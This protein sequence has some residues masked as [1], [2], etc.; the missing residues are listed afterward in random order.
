[1]L[2]IEWVRAD[3]TPFSSPNSILM[4]PRRGR[5]PSGVHT[6]RLIH[7]NTGVKPVDLVGW[8]LVLWAEEDDDD[9]D[10]DDDDS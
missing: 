6:V 10:D 4:A 2:L 5:N 3:C 8:L 7:C 9:D 1:M